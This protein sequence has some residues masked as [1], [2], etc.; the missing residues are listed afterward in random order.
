MFH[1]VGLHMFHPMGYW[2][3]LQPSFH[4]CRVNRMQNAFTTCTLPHDI[5]SPVSCND[6]MW[7]EACNLENTPVPLVCPGVGDI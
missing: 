7:H 2:C 5:C 3:V 6:M 1:D 4:A